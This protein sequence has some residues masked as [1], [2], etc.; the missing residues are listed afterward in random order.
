MKS[1]TTDLTR[2]IVEASVLAGA[3][4][5]CSVLG[6]RW[7]FR[8]GRNCGCEGTDAEGYRWTGSCSMPVY[9]CEACG[10]CDYG[11]SV[12]SRERVASCATSEV[13]LYA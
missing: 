12:E 10:D 2:L 13:M 4:H 9:E 1:E 8:G 6:H 5:P 11:D 3:P 7:A